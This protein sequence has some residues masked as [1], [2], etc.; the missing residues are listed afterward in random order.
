MNVGT[1]IA[2]AVRRYADDVALICGDE[3]ITFQALDETTNRLAHALIALGLRKGDR[4]ATL[5]ENSNR[6]VELDFA[7][8]KAGMVRVSLNPRA[9]AKDATYILADSD[10]RVLIYGAGYAQVIADTKPAAETVEQWIRI[11]EFPNDPAAPLTSLDYDALI[12]KAPANPVDV[13]VDPEDLYCLF[14]TS[15]TTGRPKGVMLSHR[16]ILQVSYNL[17]LDVGPHASGE[18]V[19]LMQPM[20]HGAGFFVLPWFMRGG[21]SV[22]MRQFDPAEV[23]RLTREHEIETVK[24][25]PTMLQ[26]VLRV[27]GAYPVELPKLRALIYGASPMPTEALRD[28]IAKFGPRL[29]QIYGQSEAP[30]TMTVLPLEDHHPDCPHPERLASAGRPWTTVEMKIVDDAGNEVPANTPGEVVLRAPQL[31]HGYWKRDDLT[32]EILRNGWL[33]TKDMGRMD[34]HGYVYLLGRKDE[35]IISGGYNIAPREI[36][37]VIYLH[38][39]VQECAVI[40]EADP[41]WGQAVVA[42]VAFRDGTTET[43]LI[44]FLKPQLGFKRPKRVYRVRELPKNSNGKI[45]KTVLKPELALVAEGAAQ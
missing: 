37:E 32:A 31:M 19:L 28:A 39:G 40:G 6:C 27:E 36:E 4:V 7:L 42:Y 14:Y 24:L 13:A 43:E 45:Q 30:V 25:I 9:T 20:S 17:L 1:Q 5:L 29:I 23:L 22:I 21:V 11:A 18:K 34:A 35:M 44:E 16:S 33:H 15:G 41:E 38:P 8:A 26:R 12:A 2:R 3:T 10:A